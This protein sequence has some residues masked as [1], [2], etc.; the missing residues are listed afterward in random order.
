MSETP[1]TPIR[2]FPKYEQVNSPYKKEHGKSTLLLKLDSDLRTTYLESLAEFWQVEISAELAEQL[3][4]P[5]K[6]DEKGETPKGKLIAILKEHLI[7]KGL[8]GQ[9]IRGIFVIHSK[10]LYLLPASEPSIEGEKTLQGKPDSDIGGIRNVRNR[11]KNDNNYRKFIHLNSLTISDDKARE[12]CIKLNADT[13]KQY[14]AILSYETYSESDESHSGAESE[15]GSMDEL[16]NIPEIMHVAEI[17]ANEPEETTTF[18]ASTPKI[19]KFDAKQNVDSWVQNQVYILEMSGLRD[20][21]KIISH[22]LGGLGTN[23]LQAVRQELQTK[24]Q[25]ELKTDNFKQA[26]RNAAHQ[27]DADLIRQLSNLKFHPESMPTMKDLYL[28]ITALNQALYPKVKD[29]ETQKTMNTEEF[30][31]KVPKAIRDS[32]NFQISDLKG[33]D[34]VDLAQRL[35]DANKNELETN[36]FQSGG[37]K[38]SPFFSNQGG[39]F[40]KKRYNNNRK[41]IRCN[42][43]KIPGHK[44]S[45]CYRKKREKGQSNGG[46][47]RERNNNRNYKNEITC[48]FCK[49]RGHIEAECKTKQRL[50]AQFLQGRDKKQGRRDD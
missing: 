48:N 4:T 5:T 21:K 20:Q 47:D 37:N 39:R 1:S 3:K 27:T 41:Q 45:E 9:V 22:L 34:L 26:L 29:A 44:E 25:E 42:Y 8:S 13:E 40:S 19:E 31:K 30:K 43:C 14:Y 46:Q 11:L 33:Y 10:K 35:A 32:P 28:K 50:Q 12:A 17:N 2:R 18:K 49:R 36:Y 38:K 15:T 16:L 6:K 7:A 24:N 23:L